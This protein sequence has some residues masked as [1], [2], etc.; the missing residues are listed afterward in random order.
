MCIH[1]YIHIYIY[2]WGMVGPG[3]DE[4]LEDGE[5]LLQVFQAPPLFQLQ[6]LV[7]LIRPTERELSLNL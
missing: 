2:I 3:R 6:D 4:L 1:I 5:L 7:F